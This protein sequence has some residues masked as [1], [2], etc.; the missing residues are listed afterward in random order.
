MQ[1]M[2]LAAWNSI[3]SIIE[4]PTVNRKHVPKV[5]E[6]FDGPA[7]WYLGQHR[8]QWDRCECA[9]NDSDLGEVAEQTVAPVVAGEVG[10]L[11]CWATAGMEDDEQAGTAVRSGC[12][13]TTPD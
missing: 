1:I 10:A 4:G 8:F 3:S 5:L 11:S 13:I 9:G 7:A 6:S 12:H 2:I